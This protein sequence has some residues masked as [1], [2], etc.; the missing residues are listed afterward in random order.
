MDR[1]SVEHAWHL[2][3]GP[4][5]RFTWPAGRPQD[6]GTAVTFTPAHPLRTGAYYRLTLDRSAHS[7]AG[8]PSLRRGTRLQP[9]SVAF[10]TGDALQVRSYS[11]WNGTKAVPANGLIAIAF[12]HPMVALAGLSA[13]PQPFQSPLRF[14][15]LGKPVPK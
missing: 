14:R 7:A 4:D 15:L 10:S 3:P 11:P 2:S 13:V 9:F 5:G 6:A 8:H 12:N 1:A